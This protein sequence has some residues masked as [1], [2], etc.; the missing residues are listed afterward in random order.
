ATGQPACAA[1]NA[2]RARVRSTPP[3]A[4]LLQFELSPEVEVVITCDGMEALDEVARAPP[5]LAVVIDLSMPGMTG[6][7]TAL[8]IRRSFPSAIR[9]ALIAV[10]GDE[11]LLDCARRSWSSALLRLL[12]SLQA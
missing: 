8:A 1:R 10:S 2:N 7:E 6:L 5:P 9:T 11:N 3:D 4:A 12:R